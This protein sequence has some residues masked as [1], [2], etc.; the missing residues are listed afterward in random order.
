[1]RPFSSRASSRRSPNQG[2]G[3]KLKTGIASAGLRGA[4]IAAESS[5]QAGD[6]SKAVALIEDVSGGSQALE[7]LL[8]RARELQ[9]R[10]LHDD[11]LAQAY[12]LC[13]ESRFEEALAAVKRAI[14]EFAQSS[15]SADLRTRLESGAVLLRRQQQRE[16]A[17]RRLRELMLTS[18]LKTA[19]FESVEARSAGIARDRKLAPD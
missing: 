3:V 4:R 7:D 12:R 14:V 9:A 13:E 8:S 18:A 2:P 16:D 15:E 5:I 6:F 19:V 11:L 1:M 17:V 10:K